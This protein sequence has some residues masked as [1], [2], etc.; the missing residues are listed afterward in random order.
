MKK[1]I[2]A[3]IM[4][5]VVPAM[6]L[7]YFQPA[8][9]T[10]G[11]KKVAVYSQEQ[12]QRLFG[13]G[14]VLD[15]ERQ[16][17]AGSEYASLVRFNGGMIQGGGAVAVTAATNTSMTAY[18][19][20]SFNQIDLTPT[21]DAITLTL[22][23]T[24][25]MFGILP[26]VGDTK[27]IYLRNLGAAATTTTIVAGAGIDLRIPETTGADVVIDGLQNATI[28]FKRLSSSVVSALV[29]EDKVGD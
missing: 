24:S 29:Y 17:A 7:A 15:G 22:P 3:V 1:I 20:K 9:L 4:A 27:E 26:K 8:T 5:L 12:A 28:I 2:L 23:G 25:T 18:Q 11:V 10:N 13:K 6:T 19:V 16:G 14:Y 21:V